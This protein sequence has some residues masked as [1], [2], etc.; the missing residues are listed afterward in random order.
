VAGIDSF[1]TVEAVPRE[2]PA[3]HH[4]AVRIAVW[5]ALG[6]ASWIALVGAMVGVL[7]LVG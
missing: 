2:V 7:R 6:S 5:V 4:G 1:V 3:V